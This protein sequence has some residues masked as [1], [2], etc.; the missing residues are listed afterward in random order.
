LAKDVSPLLEITEAAEAEEDSFLEANNL[1]LNARQKKGKKF[2]R[3]D[4]LRRKTEQKLPAP[5]EEEWE[6]ENVPYEIQRLLP[7]TQSRSVMVRSVY[8]G[9]RRSL[10][11]NRS[12]PSTMPLDGGGEEKARRLTL[13]DVAEAVRSGA[14]STLLGRNTMRT[15]VT[16][17]VEKQEEAEGLVTELE[18]AE[19]RREEEEQMWRRNGMWTHAQ[20]SNQTSFL[21][22]LL[23]EITKDQDVENTN[24]F[25]HAMIDDLMINMQE[26]RV[27]MNALKGLY[28]MEKRP[29]LNTATQ[30]CIKDVQDKF[31]RVASTLKLLSANLEDINEDVLRKIQQLSSKTDIPEADDTDDSDSEQESQ[32]Q[33]L[34]GNSEAVQESQHQESLGERVFGCVSTIVAHES[35]LHDPDVE[36]SL[37]ID[38]LED[39]RKRTRE[40]LL[41]AVQDGTLD[42]MTIDQLEDA[43]KRTR[44]VQPARQRPHAKLWRKAAILFSFE[45]CLFGSTVQVLQ[46]AV[47]EIS[48]AAS[49]GGHKPIE[50]PSFIDA[51]DAQELE[52]LLISPGQRWKSGARKLGILRYLQ[53]RPVTSDLGKTPEEDDLADRQTT[54][55]STTESW[56]PSTVGNSA[57]LRDVPEQIRRRPLRAPLLPSEYP[58]IGGKPMVLPWAVDDFVFK[59]AEPEALERRL[60]HPFPLM[61]LVSPPTSRNR[62]IRKQPK[63]LRKGCKQKD[64]RH[65]TVEAVLADRENRGLRQSGEKGEDGFDPDAHLILF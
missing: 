15:F 13:K 55:P 63:Q 49:E 1:S 37:T 12:G 64:A 54:V 24:D 5:K 16:N 52:K 48:K 65:F 42:A 21:L 36:P 34:D 31:A 46:D 7:R 35:Q 25:A 8:Q 9:A 62:L 22:D 28:A 26:L 3:L 14:R 32:L 45:R 23:E 20:L 10:C 30:L 40:A 58:A 43:P 4:K 57:P 2:P 50:L 41:R 33:D 27:K 44:E 11:V 53:G 47:K 29:A 6:D 17:M 39:A 59:I 19:R 56:R 61:P 18:I 51:H 38:E 60:K